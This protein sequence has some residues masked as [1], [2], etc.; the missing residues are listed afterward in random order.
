[1]SDQSPSGQ[2]PSYEIGYGKPPKNGQ[3]VAGK[4]GNPRGRP[5]G[6]KNLAS[7]VLRESRQIVLVKGPN[8]SRKLTK[9]EAS[10][11]QL[12]TKSA[13]GDLRA[14]REFYSLIK[15][16]EE[17][18]NSETVA[19]VVHELDRQMMESIRKRMQSFQSPTPTSKTE[20]SQ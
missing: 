18:V 8:G 2:N 12:G 13:Q 14:Q 7:V 4:S 15:K 5:K 16:S 10:V 3:F 6:S 20:D 9:L 11:M 17:S 19:P 1:M